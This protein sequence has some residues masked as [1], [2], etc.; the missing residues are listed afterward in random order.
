M[1][2][3]DQERIRDSLTNCSKGEAKKMT[4]PNLDTVAWDD[5]DFFGWVD[6][7]AVNNAYLV[8][9]YQG[10]VVGISLRMAT[11]PRS[12]LRS[13]MCAFCHTIHPAS[14]IVLFSAR[15]SG[16]SGK[17]GD[18]VGTYI[19]RDLACSLYVRG[20]RKSDVPQATETI[21]LSEK[22]DRMVLNV[23]M[24]VSRVLVGE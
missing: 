2:P 3:L 8:L 14:D 5:L 15:K 19:C 9:P 10:E 13:S 18:T 1:Q 7:R 16:K 6:P 12:K 11:P 24:F 20:K 21:D 22:I 23:E 17:K 4:M